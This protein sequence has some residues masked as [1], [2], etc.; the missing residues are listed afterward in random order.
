MIFSYI[1]IDPNNK[2]IKG[3]LEADDKGKV[4]DFLKSKNLFIVNIEKKENPI[5]EYIHEN[6]STISFTD[7]VD[8]TRQIAITLNAGLTIVDSLG[9]LKKQL[10]N[11]ALLKIVNKIDEDVKGGSSFSG[12]LKKFPSL[13]SNLYI[14]LIK[15]GEASGKLDEI[16]LKLADNLEKQRSFNSKIKGA[17][18]YPI[19]VISAMLIVMFIVVTFVIP[20][21]LDLYKDFNI[22]LPL[23]TQILMAVSGFLQMF[24][25]LIIIGGIM[26][27]VSLKKY[28][29]TKI[30]KK[31]YDQFI[32]KIPV[33]SDIVKMSSL[34]DTTRTFSILASAGVS[35]LETLN[36]VI[37]TSPNVIYQEAFAEI[38]KKVEK[39][40]SFGRSLE[41]AEIFPSILV[42]MAIV[43]EQT[44]HL[45]ETLL[46]MS[47]Y[48]EME[49]ELAVKSMVT[50]IEPAILIVMGVM[51]GFF[52]I[53]VITPIYSLTNSFK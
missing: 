29:N 34:V 6:F 8:L 19:I 22:D 53:S 41:E 24:W 48:F 43:G 28:L 11:P 3:K 31:Q 51:V 37:E 49:S 45:D 16:L 52:V 5:T 4:V 20:K 17:L 7:I 2:T 10:K 39:G 50:L 12:S 27:S 35:I 23:S 14:S 21:L 38:Y 26:G 36:I 46:R 13:F 1:A 42:Q 18:V 47:N 25:P 32:L 44:G 30:G 15:A 40:M 33:I 9:I